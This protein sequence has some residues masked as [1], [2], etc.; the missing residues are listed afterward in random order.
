MWPRSC[1]PPAARMRGG[2]LLG[3]GPS[4]SLSGTAR[5]WSSLW[6]GGTQSGLVAMARLA[7]PRSRTQSRG[8]VEAART[9]PSISVQHMPC[10]QC[11]AS[12]W[13]LTL[14]LGAPSPGLDSAP[15]HLLAWLMCHQHC[16]CCLSPL[17]LRGPP[18]PVLGV[19]APQVCQPLGWQ[20]PIPMAHRTL[21]LMVPTTIPVGR[22]AAP[23]DTAPVPQDGC[24]RTGSTQPP[25][26]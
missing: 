6:G 13:T 7:T 10:Q 9:A 23:G 20:D 26:S 25:W 8:A 1:R 5:G 12:L 14:G 3:P 2:T 19:F 22:I 16:P 4:S 18:L 11:P 15:G 21:W 24:A 17:I